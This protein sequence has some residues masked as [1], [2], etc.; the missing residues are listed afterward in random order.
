MGGQRH[1]PTALPHEDQVSII[2]EAGWASE[3]VW[4]SAENI[5]LHRDSIPGL[6][7]P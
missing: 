4:T 3:W 7:R 1:V 6:T 5:L 2:Q